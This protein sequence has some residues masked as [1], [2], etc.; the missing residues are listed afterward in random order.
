ME[1]SELNKDFG[2][3]NHYMGDLAKSILWR[4]LG[5]HKHIGIGDHKTLAI[6]HYTG[7]LLRMANIEI[8]GNI[9]SSAQ[10]SRGG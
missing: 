4:T 9:S 5:D 7:D 8:T 6:S 2:D 1:I 3:L 10:H